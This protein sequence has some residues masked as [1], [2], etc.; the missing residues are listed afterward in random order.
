MRVN[1]SSNGSL[2]RA[3]L[4]HVAPSV[5]AIEIE[6][7]AQALPDRTPAW[8]VFACSPAAIDSQEVS[9]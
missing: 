9:L 3:A 8:L 2:S 6:S 5:C 1:R 7:C 4:A